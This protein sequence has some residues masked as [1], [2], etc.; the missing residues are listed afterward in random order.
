MNDEMV[1]GYEGRAL[2]RRFEGFKLTAY[3]DVVGIWTIGCGH[4]GP[5]VKQGLTIT[6]EEADKLLSEDVHEAQAVI[7]KRVKVP[8]KQRQFDALVAFIFNVGVYAFE[9]STML[10]LLN[11][12]DYEGAAKQFARWNRAGGMVVLGLINRREAET[13]LFCD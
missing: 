10:K 11:H 2:L 6:Q 7:Y 5:E 12:G 4:T 1:L 9:T 3:K 13:R 8:L